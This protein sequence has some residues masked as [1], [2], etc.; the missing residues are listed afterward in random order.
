MNH[1]TGSLPAQGSGGKSHSFCLPYKCLVV[2]KMSQEIDTIE[3]HS[4]P[5]LNLE[6]APIPKN[7]YWIGANPRV[8]QRRLCMWHS[9]WKA[10]RLNLKSLGGGD[11]PEYEF[12]KAKII[13]RI[14]LL[15]EYCQYYPEGQSGQL[16]YM[17]PCECRSVSPFNYAGGQDTG[18]KGT[19][20]SLLN[21]FR[22]T[23]VSTVVWVYWNKV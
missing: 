16:S 3:L 11:E 6:M 17:Y 9:K 12:R 20:G 1:I 13:K 10:L 5:D 15:S 21:C 4:Q 14:F 19:I 8:F 23:E 2:Q 22:K 7:G 18:A